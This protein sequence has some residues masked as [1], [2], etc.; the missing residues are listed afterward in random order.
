NFQT[1][2]RSQ[3]LSSSNPL[4]A[5]ALSSSNPL[6]LRLS[7]VRHSSQAHTLQLSLLRRLSSSLSCKHC[8][9]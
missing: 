1:S 2:C 7:L 8:T 6:K 4:H 5:Q 9:S 3:A